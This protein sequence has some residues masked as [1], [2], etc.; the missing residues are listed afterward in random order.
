MLWW[1]ESLKTGF[2]RI[3]KQHMEIFARAEEMISVDENTPATKI[4]E[5]LSFLIDYV[6]THFSE[7]ERQMQQSGYPGLEHHKE[8]HE[9]FVKKLYAV[10]N[11]INKTGVKDNS[12]LEF[13]LLIVEWLASH[14]NECDREF[15]EYLKKN[16]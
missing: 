15:V 8:H 4:R 12:L 9:L 11:L 2:E 6:L 13:K 16:N 7:E 10:V 1:E 14:I 5:M 3:D